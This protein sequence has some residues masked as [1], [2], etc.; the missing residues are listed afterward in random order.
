MLS[1][2]ILLH[3]VSCREQRCVGNST[4]NRAECEQTIFMYYLICCPFESSCMILHNSKMIKLHCNRDMRPGSSIIK[5]C[6]PHWFS[7]SL[8]M[9]ARFGSQCH[10]VQLALFVKDSV[11]G[12]RDIGI[13]YAAYGTPIYLL[14]LHVEAQPPQYRPGACAHILN[15][16]ANH[17]HIDDAGASNHMHAWL[18]RNQLT[19]GHLSHTQ[20]SA[21]LPIADSNCALLACQQFRSPKHSQLEELRVNQD[22]SHL[23]SSRTSSS[24]FAGPRLITKEACSIDFIARLVRPTRFHN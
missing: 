1:K 4:V 13:V 12:T 11:N 17:D 7:F 10:V 8:L 20:C 3:V 15:M 5:H 18:L 9:V 6:M 19:L 22:F 23:L 24:I 21:H 14:H 16:G 2:A